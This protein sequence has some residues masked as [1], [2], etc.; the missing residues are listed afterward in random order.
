MAAKKRNV[1]PWLVFFGL[2]AL[3]FATCPNEQAHKDKFASAIKEEI[4]DVKSDR[5]KEGRPIRNALN[6]AASSVESSV[7]STILLQAF[8]VDEYGVISIGKVYLGDEDGTPVTFGLFGR[9]IVHPNFRNWIR[10][11]FSD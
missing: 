5:L 8:Y 11:Q 6:S 10:E 9:V 3:A 4:K 1:W 2:I 7:M